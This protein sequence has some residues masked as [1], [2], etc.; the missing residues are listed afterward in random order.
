MT[1]DRCRK[2]GI[3]R[4]VLTDGGWLTNALTSEA[5]CPKHNPRNG[6]PNTYR[7]RVYGKK[8]MGAAY[9]PRRRGRR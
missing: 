2:C 9:R 4:P 6:A 7:G 5:Y 3:K 1:I 8:I